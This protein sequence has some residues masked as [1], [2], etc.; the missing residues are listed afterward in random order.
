MKRFVNLPQVL[1]KNMGDKSLDSQLAQAGLSTLAKRVRKPNMGSSA[2]VPHV[3]D[4]TT[5][6]CSA[7]WLDDGLVGDN[8]SGLTTIVSCCRCFPASSASSAMTDAGPR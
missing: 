5:T 2:A 3:E 1:Q 7:T 8:D 6:S 4:E